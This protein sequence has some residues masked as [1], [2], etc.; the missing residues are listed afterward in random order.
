[1]KICVIGG[2]GVRAPVLLFS[3]A[4]RRSLAG[5]G[6]EEVS[7][8]DVD[9]E[10]SVLMLRVASLLLEKEG[11]SLNF[12]PYNDVGEALD[13]A[14]AVIFT[15]RQGFEKGRAIDERICLDNGV[16][17]QETTGAAGF[18]FACRSI[19]AVLRYA[20]IAVRL[21][22][23]VKIINFTNPSGMISQALVEAGFKRSY[24]ICDSADVIRRHAC[25]YKCFDEDSVGMKVSGL[26][27]LSWTYSLKH[28]NEELIEE[29]SNDDGFLDLAGL[30]SIKD[31][32]KRRSKPAIPNEYLYYYYN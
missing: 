19:P 27:H 26:N 11:L 16:I 32:V 12:K 31:F 14:D 17:G 18:A 10:K 3:F 25:A 7:I 4:K 6:I 21:N 8:Y 2:G 13:G 22:P 1:M 9:A 20:E 23:R 29:L 15:I 24:G 5:T 28:G 30:Y